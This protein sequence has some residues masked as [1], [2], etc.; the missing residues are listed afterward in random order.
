M[1]SNICGW[2]EICR[3]SLKLYFGDNFSAFAQTLMAPRYQC[4]VSTHEASLVG[5]TSTISPAV[6]FLYHD[7]LFNHWPP[8]AITVG[9]SVFIWLPEGTRL[10]D[11]LSSSFSIQ[12]LTYFCKMAFIPFFLP[13]YSAWIPLL[14]ACLVSSLFSSSPFL[15]APL[16]LSFRL[17]SSTCL[18]LQS[19]PLHVCCRA[20]GISL[21]FVYSA[22]SELLSFRQP[23]VNHLDKTATSC[24]TF[25]DFSLWER[26]IQTLAERERWSRSP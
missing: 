2:L 19:F 4:E 17:F 25:K 13:L 7:W 18:F 16:L 23:L 20:L 8:L 26:D 9:N 24:P 1:I 22:I 3:M 11:R 5:K 15:L 10:E 21:M 6:L 12:V 14:S